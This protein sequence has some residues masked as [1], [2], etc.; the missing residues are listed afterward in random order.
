MTKL[1][2]F[3]LPLLVLVLSAASPIGILPEGYKWSDCVT[4]YDATI[5][6]ANEDRPLTSAPNP[7]ALP[8]A[9]ATTVEGDKSQVKRADLPDAPH[10][11]TVCHR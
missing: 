11:R 8:P 7:A 2:L 10:W 4:F 1:I 6:T 3:A 9:E 5:A